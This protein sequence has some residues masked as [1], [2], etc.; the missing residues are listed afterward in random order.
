MD[1]DKL[2]K[3]SSDL[4]KE[5][6]KIE[7]ARQ[8]DGVSLFQV[9]NIAA[10]AANLIHSVTGPKSSYAENLRTAHKGKTAAA[11]YLAVAGVVQAFHLDLANGYLVNIRQEVEAVVVSEI[12]SQARK[13]LKTR[14]IHPAAAIIVACAGIEEFL[15]SWCEQKSINVPEKQRSLSKF[16][17]ELRSSG[18][19]AL[20]IERRIQSWA[21]YRND[22]A[23][24]SK[25]DGITKA[26]AEKL[27]GEIED[28]VIENKEIIGA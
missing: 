5:V 20:P 21:D 8:S 27:V 4:L 12:L 6:E 18:E 28:F 24:G 22:A 16:A 13:L 17:Q 2:V 1:I 26:I 19:I 14:G 23:H 15:R 10:Q 11:Q 25:W 9:N 3:R 7:K